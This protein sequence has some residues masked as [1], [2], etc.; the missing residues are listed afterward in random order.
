MGAEIETDFRQAILD[1]MT[2]PT[3]RP[4]T[5]QDLIRLLGIGKERRNEFKRVL[6]GMQSEREIVKLDSNRY[7]LRPDSRTV[8][9]RLQRNPRGFGFVTPDAGGRDVFIPPHGLGDLMD[10]D[11]VAIRVAREDR[12]GRSR[13]EV[14]RVVERSRR[15][16][17]GI[18]RSQGGPRGPGYVEAY[19]R[20]YET[21]ILVPEGEAGP[22]RRP[23]DGVNG[24]SV[25][26]RCSVSTARTSSSTR[27]G[28]ARRC[29][30]SEA[31]SG[32]STDGPDWPAFEMTLR[33][34]TTVRP[35]APAPKGTTNRSIASATGPGSEW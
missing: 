19:D 23:S 24:G 34:S 33:C 7:A 1:L 17:L 35:E 25:H 12:E 11:R 8:T 5:I 20:L 2:R 21:P 31:V 29:S 4:G 14:V 22:A 10:G 26:G 13:G 18:Y 15:P 6:R 28:T 3:Y 30:S 32:T 27:T 9:G 16:V